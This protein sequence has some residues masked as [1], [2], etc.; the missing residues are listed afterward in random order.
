MRHQ[1]LRTL[2]LRRLNQ[3][4]HVMKS[5]YSTND[6][7]VSI[8]QRRTRYVHTYVPASPVTYQE[9]LRLPIFEHFAA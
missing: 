3:R 2:T 7:A 1:T 5:A 4:R 8:L 9:L 6:P